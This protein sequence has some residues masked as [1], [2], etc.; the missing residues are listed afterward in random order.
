MVQSMKKRSTA[1]D[2]D[3][4]RRANTGVGYEPQF[5][6]PDC[7]VLSGAEVIKCKPM[8]SVEIISI[9]FVSGM[10]NVLNFSGTPIL[11]EIVF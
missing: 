7:A 3:A 4:Q 5:V 10:V 8:Q 1:K 2:R 9:T 6:L 11:K